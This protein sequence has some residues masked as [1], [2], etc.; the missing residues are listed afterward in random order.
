MKGFPANYAVT[1]LCK[2]GEGNPQARPR[3]TF[4]DAEIQKHKKR[5]SGFFGL[6]T[7]AVKDPCG[8][9]QDIP[10]KGLHHSNCWAEDESACG[11]KPTWLCSGHNE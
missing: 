9:A 4:N 3:G 7:S 10:Q 1:D 6:L 8:G 5:Y 2:W 11:E